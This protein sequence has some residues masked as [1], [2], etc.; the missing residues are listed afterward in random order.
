M[1]ISVIFCV[2]LLSENKYDDD[3]YIKLSFSISQ[4]FTFIYFTRICFSLI[5]MPLGIDGQL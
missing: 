2:V 4:I 5:R 1:A 3:V